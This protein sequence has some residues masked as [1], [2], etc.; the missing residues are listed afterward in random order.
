MDEQITIVED[1]SD[2]SNPADLVRRAGESA[3]RDDGIG[4]GVKL[5]IVDD[6][7]EKD[8]SEDKSHD[9]RAKRAKNRRPLSSRPQHAQTSGLKNM[10]NARDQEIMN[11]RAA[12]DQKQYE[13]H[14]AQQIAIHRDHIAVAN[15]EYAL[16]MK[17]S[18]ASDAFSKAMDEGDTA[19]AAKANEILVDASTQ[20]ARL[21]DMKNAPQFQPQPMEAIPS[22]NYTEPQ[23]V[24]DE[25]EETEKDYYTQ[26]EEEEM[27]E[28]ESERRREEEDLARE[29]LRENPWADES[30]DAYDRRLHIKFALRTNKK[31]ENSL[32]EGD[33]D[34]AHGADI[35]YDVA[36]EILADNKK[37]L[38]NRS[39]S[40]QRSSSMVSPVKRGGGSNPNSGEVRIT[41]AEME[42]VS[43]LPE[44]MREKY[45]L[46]TLSHKY[47]RIKKELEAK[48]EIGRG[49]QQRH[50]TFNTSSTP[51]G[52]Y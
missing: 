13:T 1:H 27:R 10:I 41:R 20:L 22:Y 16:Q 32:L 33:A 4:E 47:L 9:D 11:L 42:A 2:E 19:E 38:E 18:A 3:K 44:V 36:K 23:Q 40:T 45:D 12:L 35:L 49:M 43:R 5:V 30:S 37:S 7:D 17:K 48:G 52:G 39:I 34:Y 24:Y 6:P 28:E 31:I 50:Q 29:F 21:E 14:Q 46:N 15:H 8:V 26:L 51:R 25:P